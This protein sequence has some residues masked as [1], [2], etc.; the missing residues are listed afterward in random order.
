MLVIGNGE[1]RKDIDISAFNETKVGCNAIVRDF[2]VNHLVCVDRRMVEEV[3]QLS[4]F[5]KIYTRQDWINSYTS[6]KNVTTVPK[7]L[8]DGTKRWD[9]PFQWGSGPYAVLLSAK[10]C[11]G[12]TVR[13]VGF[14]L[15]SATN[16][17]NNLYKDTS[18]YDPADKNAVDPRYWVHQINKV[19][20]WFPQLHFKIYQKEDC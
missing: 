17:V 7:L 4:S 15:H 20:E 11:K 8:E 2:F 13:L 16:T 14:D 19:F 9:E 12:P 18:N 3:L 6:N 1:S 5:D 10:L